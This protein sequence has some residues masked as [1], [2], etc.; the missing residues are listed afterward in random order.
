MADFGL[1]R[2]IEKPVKAYT[3]QV[4]LTPLFQISGNENTRLRIEKL[5]RI[6]SV[7]AQITY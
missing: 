5:K 2:M 4:T 1:A 7:G 3:H 6:L